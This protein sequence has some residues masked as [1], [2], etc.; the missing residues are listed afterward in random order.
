MIL[1]D[2]NLVIDAYIVILLILWFESDIVVTIA[3][4]FRL[5]NLFKIPDFI[6][7]KLQVDVMA[8]Y[9]QYLYGV[10][11]FWGTKLLT[12]AICL[13][14]WTS[15]LGSCITVFILNYDLL[16]LLLTVP[17]NYLIVLTSYLIVKKLL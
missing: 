15:M 1:T 16:F 5:T 2:I 17:F 3:N 13:S 11:P 10:K 4:L 9:P 12:C 8:T 7:Y 14:F 6:N